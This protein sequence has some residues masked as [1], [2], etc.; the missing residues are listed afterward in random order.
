MRKRL[1]L[2][3]LT[4]DDYCLAVEAASVRGI[5][6]G[7]IYD[8]LLGHCALKAKAETIYTWNMRDFSRLGPEIAARVRTP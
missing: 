8:A 4:E 3:R 5:A 1:T 6:G 7:A 2:V